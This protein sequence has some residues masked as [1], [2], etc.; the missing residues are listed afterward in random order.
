MTATGLGTFSIMAA[1]LDDE[2]RSL[3]KPIVVSLRFLLY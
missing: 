3:Q 1:Y 2:K